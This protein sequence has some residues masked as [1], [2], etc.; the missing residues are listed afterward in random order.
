MRI[1]NIMEN[2]T[3]LKELFVANRDSIREVRIDENCEELFLEFGILKLKNCT[4]FCIKSSGI[5]I[6]ELYLP[7]AKFVFYDNGHDKVVMNK[8]VSQE[9]MSITIKGKLRVLSVPK[10]ICHSFKILSSLEKIICSVQ[11]LFFGKIG[12]FIVSSCGVVSILD[13]TDK[14]F[15][16]EHLTM[17]KL[18]NAKDL[19]FLSLPKCKKLSIECSPQLQKIHVPECEDISIFD[20]PKLKTLSVPKCKSFRFKNVPSLETFNA[21][22]C[23]KYH[24]DQIDFMKKLPPF[25]RKTIIKNGKLHFM[26]NVQFSDCNIGNLTIKQIF[27]LDF[28]ENKIKGNIYVKNAG[29]IS[30]LGQNDYKEIYIKKASVISILNAKIDYLKIGNCSAISITNSE[31]KGERIHVTKCTSF[32]AE[33]SIFR[34][35]VVMDCEF[36]DIKNSIYEYIYSLSDIRQTFKGLCCIGGEFY[37]DA[38]KIG[39][40]SLMNVKTGN[41]LLQKKFDRLQIIYFYKWLS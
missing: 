26:G 33:G 9:E 19:E 11:N 23:E 3:S 18:H 15:I 36:L 13:Y 28:H 10:C 5:V 8:T 14:V 21:P 1:K 6:K 2:V 24:F 32:K 35:I 31:I 20:S 39:K 12:P 22:E 37:F 40:L 34:N 27:L 30:F 38:R 7:K 29:E 41:F 4:Y 17:L 16:S 25:V